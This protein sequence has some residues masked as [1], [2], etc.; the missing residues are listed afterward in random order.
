[1]NVHHGIGLG[2]H[3][4]ATGER[5]V[6]YC[7]HCANEWWQDQHGLVCPN[8]DGEVTEVVCLSTFF[9]TA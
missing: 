9:N 1:M 2:E 5:K 3:L 7:H 8:C 6:V 4:D